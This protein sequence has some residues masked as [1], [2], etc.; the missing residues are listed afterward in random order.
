MARTPEKKEEDNP[1]DWVSLAPIPV[2]EIPISKTP[3]NSLQISARRQPMRTRKQVPGVE[4]PIPNPPTR[5]LLIQE[6]LQPATK[7]KV[8]LQE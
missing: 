2:I 1:P 5:I 4:I 8:S 6:E 7:M 3:P